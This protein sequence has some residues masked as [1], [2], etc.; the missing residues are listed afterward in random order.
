MIPLLI[1][2][3]IKAR[4][5]KQ[6][7]PLPYDLL[8]QPMPYVTVSLTLFLLFYFSDRSQ[9]L[10][11]DWLLCSSVYL[12]SVWRAFSISKYISIRSAMPVYASIFVNVSPQIPEKYIQHPQ[13]LCWFSPLLYHKLYPKDPLEVDNVPFG[14]CIAGV[15]RMMFVFLR[16]T[17]RKMVV[18]EEFVLFFPFTPEINGGS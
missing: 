2:P 10:T 6:L 11:Y 17:K 14:L 5:L 15:T 18:A 9:Q 3:M 13:E 4:P 1:P 7:Y 16:K 12:F 8:F